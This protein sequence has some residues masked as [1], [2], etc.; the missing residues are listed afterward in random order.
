ME[1]QILEKANYCAGCV[2]KPCQI[3]CPLNNDTTGFIKLVKEKKYKEAYELSCKTTVLQSI[4]GRICPHEKQCQGS[5]AKGVSYEPVSIGDIEAFIGDLAIKNNWKIPKESVKPK[6]KKIAVIGAGPAGLTCSAFLAREGYSVTI[7][8]KYEKLGGILEHGI[9][10][11]RL[12]KELLKNAINK[13]IELGITVV[14]NKEL[15]KD[16]LLEN[17]EKEYD[18]IFLSFGANI[19]NKMNIEGENLEGVYGGN[20]LLESKA[21]SDYKNKKVIVSGG[22]NVAMDTARTVKRLG[23]KDV[24]IIY[25]RAK[26]QMPAE[27][28]EIEEA[29][30]EGINFVFQTNIIKIL[31]NSQVEKI[32]CVKTELIKKEGEE[33]KVP[34]NI[35]GS[36]YFIDADYIIM[37]VGSKAEKEILETLDLEINSRGRI[38]VDKNKTSKEKV[39]AG[40]DLIGEKSTVAWAA[41]SGRNA[42]ENIKQYLKK[43]EY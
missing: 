5:C 8:E 35:E 37:A 9:P 26:E 14:T 20:E 32:E 12:N 4:C 30:N 27:K 43:E 18:A 11:F 31:G 10:E 33:R 40:G 6:D 36:N 23:A 21:H 13:I 41:R 25:R 16:I 15:G 1:K 24:T 3:G 29:E 34:C 38:K 39:F 42:A 19:S 28:K 7:Y 17:L 2:T 22:G